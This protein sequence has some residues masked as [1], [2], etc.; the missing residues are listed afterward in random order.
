MKFWK[1]QNYEDHKSQWF[2][3][4]ELVVGRGEEWVG[5]NERA[6]HR[7]FFEERRIYSLYH[8][9]GSKSLHNCPNQ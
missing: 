3:G 1:K 9:D 6:E 2:P 5:R 7:A 4:V 8:N